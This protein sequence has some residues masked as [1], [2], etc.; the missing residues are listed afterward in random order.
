MK[1]FTWRRALKTGALL[2][3]LALLT[4]GAYGAWGL[5]RLNAFSQATSDK[6]LS[7]TELAARAGGSDRFNLLVLGYGGENHDG[8]Y[9][10]DSIL[11]HSV[12]LS[13]GPASQISVPRD[14]WIE[15]PPGSNRHR[16]V[17][18]AYAR[19]MA[20]TD[21]ARQA[22]QR[23]VANISSALGVPIHGWMTVDF[24]GFRD[25]VDALGGV[26]VNVPRGFTARYPRSDD[27]RQDHR[28]T[29][30]TFKPG[31]QLM[32]GERAI[33]YA[34][35][36]YSKD[37]RESTDF[38]R[39]VRQQL[40]V[41]AI[42]TKLLSPS[43]LTRGHKVLQALEDDVLTNVS[44]R[45]LASLF[46]REVPEDHKIVLGPA[47]VLEGGRSGSGQAILVPRDGDWSALRRFV[48]SSLEGRSSS[49]QR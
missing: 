24:N 47:N 27:P 31:P 33:R 46:R 28:W 43:G 15:S 6:G 22:A 49:A 45:D 39:A 32:G 12:S 20:S 37:P 16:K 4:A 35:A 10:T 30:I 3:I 21:N 1:S 29:H 44:A 42:K 5:S 7:A 19:A 8:A 18:S 25:L 11:I 13:G 9:L 17:N 36:R 23:A 34:R 2:L 26:V 41:S 40:L 48:R 14:L 38:A